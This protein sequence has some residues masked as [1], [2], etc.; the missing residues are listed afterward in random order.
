MRPNRMGP[1]LRPG[2][3]NSH[4]GAPPGVQP[5]V[6]PFDP[7]GSPGLTPG[8]TPEPRNSVIVE[9]QSSENENN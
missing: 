5:A 4:R 1:G 6:R 9:T 8:W 3:G 2:V 7:D